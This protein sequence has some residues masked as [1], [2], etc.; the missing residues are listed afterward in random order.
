MAFLRRRGGCDKKI[1]LNQ[2]SDN[3]CLGSLAFSSL[4]FP[5]PSPL[6]TPPALLSPLVLDSPSPSPLSTPACPRFRP[7]EPLP[8]CL[9]LFLFLIATHICAKLFCLKTF[10]L[11]VSGSGC[12]QWKRT[13]SSWLPWRHKRNFKSIFSTYQCFT[14]LFYNSNSRT[15]V[16]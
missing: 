5:L 1:Q 11:C 16:M 2:C 13:R 3:L 10:Y 7:F 6:S 4:D 9:I 14:F 15:R 8:T 12:G